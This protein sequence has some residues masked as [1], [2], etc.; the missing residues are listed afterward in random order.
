[1]N[2]IQAMEPMGGGTLRLRSFAESERVV[3]EV[4]DTGPGILEPA[5]AH[6]FEPF[7]TTKPTGTG[8]GLSVSYGIVASHGGEITIA[9]T[10]AS[11]TTFRISLPS[12]YGTEDSA[13]DSIE[14]ISSDTPL[15]GVHMLFVDD[16]LA[17]HSAI[18]SYA[19]ARGFTVVTAADGA[20]ALAAARRERFDVVACD[21]RMSGLDGPALFEILRREHPELA[22]RTLFITGD[23]MSASSRSFLESA[24]QPVLEKPFDLELLESSLAALL[25]DR[26]ELAASQPGPAQAG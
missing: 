21:L 12:L 2:A 11:G 4:S 1:M 9:N 17:L 7:Y 26:E 6:V 25:G 24:G 23:L 20:A 16:E 15:S 18:R 10:G 19:R 14:R 3:L 22:A 8:L 5:R 13:P